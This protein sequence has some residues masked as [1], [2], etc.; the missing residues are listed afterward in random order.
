MERRIILTRLLDKYENS[1]H[2][3]EPGVSKRRVVLRIDN[4][5]LPEYSYED[6]EVRDAY[7]Q[8]AEKCEQQGLIFITWI[9]GRPVFSEL[10]LNLDHVYEA[11]HT[12]G[13][14]HPKNTALSTADEIAQALSSV[15]T[16]WILSWQTETVQK[17]RSTYR[18]PSFF[19]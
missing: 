5:D 1:K 16:P 3:L 17:I 7:N 18:I 13:K 15:S 19:L 10:I 12:I 14:T 2:L 11:Y 4:K 9:S 6:A 8:A